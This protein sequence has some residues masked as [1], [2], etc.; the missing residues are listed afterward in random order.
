MHIIKFEFADIV[1]L[2]WLESINCRYA[3]ALSSKMYLLW[4]YQTVMILEEWRMHCMFISFVCCL[5]VNILE[6]VIFIK[7]IM[8][9]VFEYLT[10]TYGKIV[11]SCMCLGVKST[12]LDVHNH[13]FHTWWTRA[14][15]SARML[16]SMLYIAV[17][18]TKQI[19]FVYLEAFFQDGCQVSSATFTLSKKSGKH[20]EIFERNWKNCF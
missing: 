14:P 1:V 8:F 9:G 13:R 3:Q 2:K 19:V 6:Y 16:P 20:M 10:L 15:P 5:Y 17:F 18:C 4:C 11:V 7:N 12:C